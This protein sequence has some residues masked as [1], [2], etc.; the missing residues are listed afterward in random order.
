VPVE[1]QRSTATIDAGDATHHTFT[2]APTATYPVDSGLS[3]AP[4]AFE[5]PAG[6]LSTTNAQLTAQTSNPAFAAATAAPLSQPFSTAVPTAQRSVV[7]ESRSA[8]LAPPI[9][10]LPTLQRAK[11]AESGNAPA[12]V[13]AEVP[14]A[15][16]PVDGPPVPG[17]I[18]LLPPVRTETRQVSADSAQPMSLQRMFGDFGQPATG[19]GVVRPRRHDEPPAVPTMTF[20]A[21]TAQREVES[22]PDPIPIAQTISEH[23][24]AEQTPS[25][26]AAPAPASAAAP[27]PAPTDVDELVGRLYEPLAAR[28]RAELWLD[29]E[30]AGALMNLHR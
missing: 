29:R 17:R 10:A 25:V 20:D 3:R 6:R 22:A 21:P 12:P 14:T 4:E 1:V 11:D 24:L 16:P 27:A 5:P 13:S 26:Q 7:P 30:R 15:P 18:V 8:D 19:S 23:S 28:L 9:A 2:S